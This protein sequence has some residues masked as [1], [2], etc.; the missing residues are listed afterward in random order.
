MPTFSGKTIN[1][2]K[3]YSKSLKKNAAVTSD[4]SNDCGT[5]EIK[6]FV[7]FNNV[8]KLQAKIKIYRLYSTLFTEV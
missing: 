8:H 6:I 2:L 7:W 4:S 5:S 1:E 3:T